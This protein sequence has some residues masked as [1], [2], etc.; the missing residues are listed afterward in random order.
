MALNTTCAVIPRGRP[1]SGR[2]AAKSV[3]SS[4]AR[5]VSTIGSARWLSAV[6]RPWPGRCL[7]DR[8]DAARQQAV[9]GGRR[10]RRDLS[11]VIAISAVADHGI[12]R[13]DRHVRDR[14]AIHIDPDRT[15]IG[16][17]SAAHRADAA[18]KRLC[19]IDLI[20]AAEHGRPAD[21]PANAAAAGAARARLPDRPVPARRILRWSRNPSVNRLHLIGIVDIALE[22]DQAPRR[23]FAQKRALVCRDVR[24]GKSRDECAHRH[25]RGLALRTSRSKVKIKD[26]RLIPL[27]DALA[28]R[29][30]QAGAELARFAL[31]AERNLR[32]IIGALVAEIG[33]ADHRLTVAEHVRDISPA[34][35]GRTIA[36]PPRCVAR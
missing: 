22:K 35:P 19:P 10:Q 20:E 14:Q 17:R 18:S 30:F 8:E 31:A 4:V 15:Q 33:A 2:N 16:R 29:G 28:A 7:S 26:E 24:A 1:A 5:S 21:K 3:A 32:A 12:A 36:H 23:R 27:D 6:A 25:R 11:G 13:S 9:G 34:R